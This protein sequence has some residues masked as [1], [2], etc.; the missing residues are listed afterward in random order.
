MCLV[1][2][3]LDRRPTLDLVGDGGGGGDGDE[4]TVD[5]TS[6]TAPPGTAPLCHWV[7][8]PVSCMFTLDARTTV[9]T[10]SSVAYDIAHA[11][12]IA[13][14]FISLNV[15]LTRKHKLQ[16]LCISVTREP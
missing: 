2:G 14:H 8:I 6:T 9:Q 11:S 5:T 16:D 1:H 15:L 7:S 10:H 4:T 13:C 3:R 12:F